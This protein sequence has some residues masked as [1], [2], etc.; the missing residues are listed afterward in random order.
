MTSCTRVKLET[1]NSE[2][3]CLSIIRVDIFATGQNAV[4]KNLDE[5][6]RIFHQV[7]ELYPHIHY[8][9]QQ[10]KGKIVSIKAMMTWR[11]MGIQLNA[12]LNWTLDEARW[13][14]S[15]PCC[16]TN[17]DFQDPLNKRL[18]G[19]QSWS[20]NLGIKTRFLS[21]L[22]PS[23]VITLT[24]V[25]HPSTFKYYAVLL[26]LTL[27]IYWINGLHDCHQQNWIFSLKVYEMNDSHHLYRSCD[28]IPQTV[29]CISMEPGTEGL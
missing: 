1:N 26:I 15:S 20:T 23:L 10:V 28:L 7:H 12:F 13:P 9:V 4:L 25:C 11:G 27:L 17:E 2:T 29:L 24:M 19:F 21:H 18:G 14:V 16:C 8:I 3:W 5:K 22:T 6:V